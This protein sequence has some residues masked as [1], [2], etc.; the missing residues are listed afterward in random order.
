MAA[1]TRKGWGGKSGLHRVRCP[2]RLERAQAG[3]ERS[4]GKCHRNTPPKTSFARTVRMK[5]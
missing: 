1:L 2:A 4:D 5:S 3:A